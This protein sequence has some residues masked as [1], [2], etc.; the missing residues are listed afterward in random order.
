[1]RKFNYLPILA[2]M[3]AFAG[4]AQAA[5]APVKHLQRATSFT[6][7]SADEDAANGSD[8]QVL[9]FKS[10]VHVKA[11]GAYTEQQTQVFKA[12]TRDGAQSLNPYQQEYSKLTQTMKVQSAYIIRANGS[13]V[14]IP[15]SDIVERPA[16]APAG[17][18][19][20][21][22]YDDSMMLSI[23]LPG[24]N[25]G[26]TLYVQTLQDQFKPIFPN[27]YSEEW[28]PT[29]NQTT[30]DQKITVY[31]PKSMKLDSA[32]LGGWT[33]THQVQ[34]DQQVI[35]GT[36]AH[37]AA[38]FPEV[39][40]VDP[41]DYTPVFEVTSFPTWASVG[42]A[43]WARAKDQAEVTPLVK[44]VADKV[45][46]N[47]QGLDAVKAIYNWESEHIHYIGL[48]LG[49]G[50]FV[51]IAANTT[52]TTG[53][54][55]CKQ[56]STL[57]EA[58]LAARGIQ[59][60][61]VLINW[62]NGFKVLPLPSP[63]FN[64]AID[65]LP[66]YHLFLD[67]TGEFET[68]GQMAIGERD[69][70]VVIAGPKSWLGTTPGAEP[71]QNKMVY[72][73]TLHLSADG[74]LSG[75]ADMTTTGWWAWF[76]R[77]IFSD[78]PPAEYGRLMSKFLSPSGGG[79]GTFQPSNPTLLDQPMQVVAHWSTPA[80]ALPGKTLSVPLPPGPY[81]VPSMSGANGPLSAL[82]AIAGPQTRKR[83]VAT[84]L[85]EIDW[86]TTLTLPAGYAPTYLPPDANVT[87]AAGSFSYTVKDTKDTVTVSYKL[88]LDHILYTPA[89]Y[90]ALR[91]LILNCLSAQR[92]PLVFH[93][94]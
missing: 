27:E 42:A 9:S 72:D 83:N 94:I 4:A 44:L 29:V 11:N 40:T 57:L 53:Y 31:A 37:Y 79:S 36:M 58:L 41:S 55:D 51:P 70:P 32:Q 87:N 17:S 74:T 13:R 35:T 89:Q 75:T 6:A 5:P 2:V 78:V 16:P 67:T 62:S 84:Y 76:Y 48:E 54:G 39:G 28:G 69:K 22:V 18:D 23:T 61:P 91:S 81:I 59:V 68:L 52:L 46:G 93:H 66:Q 47:L 19:G 86:K 14:D 38:E 64:H 25:K 65:Y 10:V 20:A 8:V 82:T 3:T 88:R 90:E 50:G 92:A 80:Y 45:A 73:A 12:L 26:D 7:T 85:S 43:Y 33:I 77:M 1:M 21:P 63:D 34:G 30:L 60:D 49:V 56:H 71:D 15:A 24:F